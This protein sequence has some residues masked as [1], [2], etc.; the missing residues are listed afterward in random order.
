MIHRLK[1]GEEHTQNVSASQLTRLWRVTLV[2]EQ[3]T[4]RSWRFL[5]ITISNALALP[6]SAPL[7]NY[8]AYPCHFQSDTHI[9]HT[10]H[11]ICFVQNG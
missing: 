8:F 5:H 7:V 6:S 4:E 3:E 9:L 10:R 11:V 2:G 1:K